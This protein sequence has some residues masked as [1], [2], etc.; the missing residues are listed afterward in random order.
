VTVVEVELTEPL[1]VAWLA[2]SL[3]LTLN[4]EYGVA[5]VVAPTL[6]EEHV[7]VFDGLCVQLTKLA[8]KL[9]AVKP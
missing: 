6:A 7:S 4:P 9:F 5:L 3:A 8:G 1:G 2:V